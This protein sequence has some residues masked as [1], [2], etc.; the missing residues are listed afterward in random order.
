MDNSYYQWFRA[1]A[2]DKAPIL[3]AETI[4]TAFFIFGGC[5]GTLSWDGEKSTTLVA[6]ITFGL[7]TMV[8]IQC[9]NHLPNGHPYLNP[10]V[11]LA[12]F[13]FHK[14]SILVNFCCIFIIIKAFK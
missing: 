1:V 10:A 7:V 11:T 9:Y 8:I 12:A 14:T 13:I 2:M 4:G 3:I 5:I 6:S